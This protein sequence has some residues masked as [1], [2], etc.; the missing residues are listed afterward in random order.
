M[1][2]RI[3]SDFNARVQDGTGEKIFIGQEGTWQIDQYPLKSHL[4][5]GEPIYLCDDE[6]EVRATL[7]YDRTSRVW[8]GRPEWSTKREVN[9]RADGWDKYAAEDPKIRMAILRYVLKPLVDVISANSQLLARK[10][11]GSADTDLLDQRQLLMSMVELTNDLSKSFD[12]LTRSW[13]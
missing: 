6:L 4:R 12:I 8:Y 13:L 3:F 11:Q 1:I 9:Y 5:P 2:A 7:E 10:H